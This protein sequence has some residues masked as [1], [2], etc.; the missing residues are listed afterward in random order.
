MDGRSGVGDSR[1]QNGLMNS[2]PVHPLPPEVRKECWVKVQDLP[3]ET[4]DHG[5][6]D[7]SQIPGEK[8]DVDPLRIEMHE[9]ALTKV[10]GVVPR[11]DHRRRDPP[12]PCNL[13]SWRIRTIGHQER[14]GPE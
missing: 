2:D 14:Y 12:L 3:R 8:K 9:K 6:R 4:P 11:R 5:C 13:Q 10:G 7:E 1:I